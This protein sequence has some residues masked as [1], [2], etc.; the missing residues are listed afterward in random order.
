MPD[1]LFQREKLS[2]YRPGLAHLQPFV[3]TKT[4]RKSRGFTSLDLAQV[5]PVHPSCPPYLHSVYKNVCFRCLI[6]ARVMIT[7]LFIPVCFLFLS[8][9]HPDV[10]R[11]FLTLL[12]GVHL[13]ALIPQVWLLSLGPPVPNP[14]LDSMSS[15]LFWFLVKILI[16]A[17]QALPEG[18]LRIKIKP[19]FI[20]IS[21]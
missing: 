10:T 15:Q 1:A 21:L 8:L 12:S 6:S 4:T 7:M 16:L 9:L 14:I 18:T 19:F 20:M 11:D 17:L 3:K 2:E 5:G 13:E